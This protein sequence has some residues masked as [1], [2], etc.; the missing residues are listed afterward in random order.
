MNPFNGMSW[1]DFDYDDNSSESSNDLEDIDLYDFQE[2][3]LKY[4]NGIWGVINTANYGERRYQF[5]NFCIELFMKHVP[6]FREIYD[7]VPFMDVPYYYN[8]RN[9]T[10]D[11]VYQP[12]GASKE[13]II[14]FKT[15]LAEPKEIEIK[16]QEV[17]MKQKYGP[18]VNIVIIVLD[19]EF[20][21][22]TKL[23][24]NET[25]IYKALRQDVINYIRQNPKLLKEEIKIRK[26]EVPD[27][28]QLLEKTFANYEPWIDLNKDYDSIYQPL[29]VCVDEFIKMVP[30]FEE[31]ANHHFNDMKN[32]GDFI[33]EVNLNQANI[34]KEHPWDRDKNRKR[35]DEERHVRSS[36]GHRANYLMKFPILDTVKK[37]EI[38]EKVLDDIFYSISARELEPELIQIVKSTIQMKLQHGEELKKLKKLNEM[39]AFCVTEAGIPQVEKLSL[40]ETGRNLTTGQF[41][42]LLK[43]QRKNVAIHLGSAISNDLKVTKRGNLAFKASQEIVRRT[44]INHKK[45]AKDRKPPEFVKDSKDAIYMKDFDFNFNQLKRCSIKAERWNVNLDQAYVGSTT[46]KNFVDQVNANSVSTLNQCI[47]S[48]QFGLVNEMWTYCKAYNAAIPRLATKGDSGQSFSMIPVENRQVMWFGSPS[49]NEMTTGALFQVVIIA[50]KDRFPDFCIPYK[51]IDRDEYTIAISAPYRENLKFVD[52]Y[53]QL[54]GAFVAYDLL[55]R[56]LKMN[57]H[58]NWLFTSFFAASARQLAFAFDVQYMLMKN[59][60]Q[61]GGFGNDEFKK[62]FEGLEFKDVRVVTILSK[63]KKNFGNAVLQYRTAEDEKRFEILDPLFEFTHKSLQSVLSTT[64]L[65]QAYLSDDGFDPAKY[66]WGFYCDELE[67]QTSWIQS[68]FHPAHTNPEEHMTGD[69]FFKKCMVNPTKWTEISYWPDYIYRITQYMYEHAKKKDPNIDGK[70]FNNK[71]AI[72][73]GKSTKV[74]FPSIV[75]E[76]PGTEKSRYKGVSSVVLSEALYTESLMLDKHIKNPTLDSPWYDPEVKYNLNSSPPTLMELC[77]YEKILYPEALVLIMKEKHQKTYKKRGFFVQT[78]HGRNVN[79]LRDESMRPIQKHQPGD[80]ILVPGPEKFVKFERDMKE[81]GYNEG[82]NLTVTEDQTKYGDTYPMQAMSLST[83]ALHKCGY[84]SE[85]EAKFNMYADS[86]I[87][88]RFIMMP[89]QC[90]KLYDVTRQKIQHQQTLSDVE[91][92]IAVTIENYA[93]LMDSNTRFSKWLNGTIIDEVRS[94]P[95]LYKS[96]GF[97]L[98]VLNIEGTS[99][100]EGHNLLVTLAW[101]KLGIQNMTRYCSH[102]DDS[103]SFTSFIIPSADIFKKKI[104]ERLDLLELFE[105]GGTIVG[106]RNIGWTFTTELGTTGPLS[107]DEIGKI[108]IIMTLIAPRT[109]GQRPSLAKWTFGDIGEILQVQCINGNVVVPFIRHAVAI[110][111]DLP[112]HS[113]GEDLQMAA[114]RV[115]EVIL[116]GSGTKL[117]ND[118][119]FA[120]NYIIYRKY[121]VPSEYLGMDKPPQFGGLWY[122][123]PAF[124]LSQGFSANEARLWANAAYDKV[125][126]RLLLLSENTDDIWMQKSDEGRQEQMNLLM[127]SF[128][129]DPT[130][131][132]AEDKIG[133]APETRKDLKIRFS[134]HSKTSK[135]F[136]KMMDMYKGYLTDAFKETNLNLEVFAEVE[137]MENNKMIRYLTK[138]WIPYSLGVINSLPISAAFYI[139]KYLTSSWA[140]SYLRI[141]TGTKVVSALGYLNRHFSNPFSEKISQVLGLEEV[142]SVREVWEAL[143]RL[144][145]GTTEPGIVAKRFAK[146]HRSMFSTYISEINSAV[147]V[148]DFTKLEESNMEKTVK[149]YKISDRRMIRGLTFRL[150]ELLS[151]HME[152]LLYKVKLS[153]TAIAKQRPQILGDEGFNQSLKTLEAILNECHFTTENIIEHQ[154]LILKALSLKDFQSITKA[155]SPNDIVGQYFGLLYSYHYKL[156]I[157]VEV[158]VI[159]SYIE[160]KPKNQDLSRVRAQT[161]ALF[162]AGINDLAP[163]PFKLYYRG[164]EDSIQILTKVIDEIYSSGAN[165]LLLTQFLVTALTK[166]YGKTQPLLIFYKSSIRPKEVVALDYSGILVYVKITNYDKGKSYNNDLVLSGGYR[167][168]ARAYTTETESKFVKVLITLIFHFLIPNSYTKRAFRDKN[169]RCTIWDLFTP[170]KSSPRKGDF[171]LFST[172][173][174]YKPKNGNVR[175]HCIQHNEMMSI[176]SNMI[177]STNKVYHYSIPVKIQNY[178]NGEMRISEKYDVVPWNFINDT[179]F[180]TV[181]FSNGDELTD[182]FKSQK[183]KK[184]PHY[185]CEDNGLGRKLGFNTR[186][187]YTEVPLELAIDLIR[188]VNR[189]DPYMTRAVNLHNLTDQTLKSVAEIRRFELYVGIPLTIFLWLVKTDKPSEKMILKSKPKK[190]KHKRRNRSDSTDSDEESIREIINNNDN[191]TVDKIDQNNNNNDNLKGPDFESKVKLFLINK[192]NLFDPDNLGSDWAVFSIKKL[193]FNSED[194]TDDELNCWIDLICFTVDEDLYASI[195]KENIH[196]QAVIDRDFNKRFGDFTNIPL[197]LIGMYLNATENCYHLADIFSRD[198]EKSLIWLVHDQSIDTVLFTNILSLMPE[199]AHI[200]SKVAPLLHS[201]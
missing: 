172:D 192:P 13:R 122:A 167:Y 28:D 25:T 92:K 34:F 3:G 111:A 70:G 121:G 157:N 61:V 57:L 100:T 160:S 8:G 196:Y 81:L 190:Y 161:I 118:L 64:Y 89:E 10:P 114:G 152:M 94:N 79:K 128:Q 141:P 75:K 146:L 69:Q 142:L 191:L 5:G 184:V 138:H 155:V 27:R 101:E 48:D 140:E 84:F 109:V 83:L 127:K 87:A 41:I 108:H 116:N 120:I 178:Q 21:F 125:L 78:L 126:D 194:L 76:A 15:Y 16:K 82:R 65:K 123:F 163:T 137:K 98:G 135:A 96:C 186:G 39:Y 197:H 164:K 187:D 107:N 113:P 11:I 193:F 72:K 67:F 185:L 32:M 148:G 1:Y 139:Q 144:S 173:L 46:L 102:S 200:L 188:I 117:A 201:V 153:G 168:K 77:C 55:S 63:L 136:M 165:K 26:R 60:F 80:V 104:F 56:E 124:L 159:D 85:C 170:N 199:C 58:E 42:Q 103:I 49:P 31:F 17:E 158:T 18:D 115:Y 93:M 38:S 35:V 90:V 62:K 44:G 110:A 133:G 179:S 47:E 91:G 95:G 24:P 4:V 43:D 145:K 176:M 30:K 37:G 171:A 106:S 9:V 51:Y 99:L 40:Q 162:H 86:C 88:N 132:D 151:A 54:V 29:N 180:M 105:V 59:I 45:G 53:T 7:A 22:R 130:Q 14:E 33:P 147:V 143:I 189:M 175:I 166:E 183:L 66:L 156:D 195:T 174:I 169:K 52:Q 2:M 97:T 68:P 19:E 182:D 131:I 20:P 154:R 12:V 36:F 150:P 6:Q 71:P 198:N 50:A 149:Y 112:S 129:I 181:K 134:K 119:L 177:P 23:R 74:L 73:T